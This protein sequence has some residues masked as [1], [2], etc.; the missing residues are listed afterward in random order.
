MVNEAASKIGVETK[1]LAATVR[2]WRPVS[3][4]AAAMVARAGAVLDAAAAR[5]TEASTSLEVLGE[6]RAAAALLAGLSPPHA[7]GRTEDGPADPGIPAAGHAGE[8]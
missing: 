4:E 1:A 3:D 2:D 5:M 7:G 6:L 8:V